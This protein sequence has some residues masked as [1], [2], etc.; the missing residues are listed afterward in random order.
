MN[1]KTT[2]YLSFS[3]IVFGCCL[4]FTL[5]TDTL[6]A[7]IQADETIV[8]LPA[9]LGIGKASVPGNAP[10]DASQGLDYRYQYLAGGAGNSGSWPNWNANGDFPKFYIEDSI[11]NDVIPVFSYYMICQATD[12]CYWD[13]VGAIQEHLSNNGIMSSYWRE[14]S[15]FFEKAA[16]FPDHPII[17]HMEPDLWGFLHQASSDDNVGT[18]GGYVAVNNVGIEA[19]S[20]LPNTPAG[21]AAAIFA[22]REAAGAN[23]VLIGYHVSAWGVGDDFVFSNPSAS[24]MVVQGDRAVAF[25]QSFNQEFDLIFSETSDRDAGYYQSIG[26]SDPYWSTQDYDN[27][28][29]LLSRINELTEKD[30]L[31]WQIPFGNTL[32]KAMNNTAYHYQDNAVETFLGESG[33]ATLD[34]YRQ[35]GVIALLFG[36]GAGGGITTCPCDD[37]GDGI[38]N[39]SP[40]SGNNLDSLSADDDGGYFDKVLADYVASGKLAIRFRAVRETAVNAIRLNWNDVGADQYEVWRSSSA[41]VNYFGA[42]AAAENCEIVTGTSYERV[43]TDGLEREYFIVVPVTN[44]VKDDPSET[45]VVERLE[46][47]LF[48]PLVFD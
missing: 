28:I 30:I 45:F 10:I 16:Q 40:I 3:I 6:S 13:E 29:T 1:N 35:A 19:I 41:V 17:L 2:V 26:F 11:D 23:N 46:A 31:I 33:Y 7:Q 48:F 4:L 38:T 15:L 24:E 47:A 18:Y 14:L 25:Y 42:C 27:H 36:Q 34:R 39:P 37:A 21:F 9:E 32:Y 8:F 44:G 22:L 20:N 5:K 12:R 43:M